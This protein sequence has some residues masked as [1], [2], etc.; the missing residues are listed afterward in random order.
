MTPDHSA[1][2]EPVAD[3][4][5]H[6]T[7]VAD[8]GGAH[9]KGFSAEQGTAP[10]LPDVIPLVDAPAGGIHVPERDPGVE[11]TGRTDPG[12]YNPNDQIASNG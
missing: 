9:S 1:R 12:P 7:P 6:P 4:V 10:P 2:T 8:P 3:P 11:P 5:P